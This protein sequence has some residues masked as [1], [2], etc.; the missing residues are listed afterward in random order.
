MFQG[1]VRRSENDFGLLVGGFQPWAGKYLPGESRDVCGRNGR[2]S[3]IPSSLESRSNRA[4]STRPM[5]RRNID[6]DD[7]VRGR[8]P[9][10]KKRLCERGKQAVTPAAARRPSPRPPRTSILDHRASVRQHRSVLSCIITGAPPLD[11]SYEKMRIGLE[12]G[13]L[14]LAG[15]SDLSLIK[16]HVMST[17][18]PGRELVEV[19]VEERIDLHPIGTDMDQPYI[20]SPGVIESAQE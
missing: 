6:G 17:R 12:L 14:L 10:S 13:S 16:Q 19:D 18:R 11:Q 3:G 20:E 4:I 7:P 8:E 2:R 5:R 15:N 1:R 9:S